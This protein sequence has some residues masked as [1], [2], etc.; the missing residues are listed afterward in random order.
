MAAYVIAN[1]HVHDPERYE[2]YKKQAHAAIAAYGGRY[3]ARG[4]THTVLEGEWAPVRLV[5]LEFDS[6]DRALEWYGSQ[7]Y[8]PAKHLRQS[9]SISQIVIVDGIR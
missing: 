7:E 1:V 5:V 9:I 6:Y 2:E 8:A 3:L 4:G